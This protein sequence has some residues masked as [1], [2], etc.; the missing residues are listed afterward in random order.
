MEDSESAEKQENTGIG[1]ASAYR[2][3]LR[4]RPTPSRVPDATQRER[5]RSGASLIRDRHRLERSRVCSAPLRAALRPGYEIEVHF[6]EMNPIVIL[7]KRTQAGSM[8]AERRTNLRLHEIPAGV[9]SLFPVVIYNEVCNSHVP[10]ALSAQDLACALPRP[11]HRTGRRS[12][13]GGASP[14]CRTRVC[15]CAYCPAKRTAAAGFNAVP[16]ATGSCRSIGT[17]GFL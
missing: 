14:S 5:Q 1:P 10:A 12:I 11:S 9:I 6:G 7:A 2:D 15:W 17:H 16:R 4:T 13:P 8:R 3:R